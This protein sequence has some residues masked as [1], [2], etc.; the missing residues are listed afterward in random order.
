MSANENAKKNTEAGTTEYHTGYPKKKG[1]YD[2]M[3]D[4]ESMKL[5]CF[6]CDLKPKS[7][8]WV[9]ESGQKVVDPVV[10]R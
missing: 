2:C 9:D 10:W 5:Y 4:D 6:I 7:P 1:W 8:Y 3:V